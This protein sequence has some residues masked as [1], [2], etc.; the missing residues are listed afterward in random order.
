MIKIALCFILRF[1]LQKTFFFLVL[2]IQSQLL[3]V[4]CRPVFVLLKRLTEEQMYNLE[5]NPSKYQCLV[6][7][8]SIDN[9]GSISEDEKT[10]PNI[11]S[12]RKAPNDESEL[13]ETKE[14]E[15]IVFNEINVVELTNFEGKNLCDE[16]NTTIIHS[17]KETTLCVKPPNEI[18][19]IDL[20]SSDEEENPCIFTSSD[21]NKDSMNCVSED[22]T[23]SL[24]EKLSSNKFQLKSH[25]CSTQQKSEWLSN[26]ILNN[27]SENYTSKYHST[28]LNT[29]TSLSPILEST[30]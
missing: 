9:R 2:S 7:N 15:K 29:R 17:I 23:N 12:K 24:L 19:V 27:D 22:V 18:T 4:L 30:P 16:N 14:N 6:R 21:K 10:K 20:C 3:Y 11:S 5:R 26:N 13:N 25:I 8:I 1:I 28:M